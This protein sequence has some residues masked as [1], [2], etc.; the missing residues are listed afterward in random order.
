[1]IKK[2]IG[3]ALLLIF[4]VLFTGCLPYKQANGLKIYIQQKEPG[5]SGKSILILNFKE[6]DYAITKGKLAARIFHETVLKSKIFYLVKLLN[7]SDWNEF[8]KTEEEMLKTAIRIG[9]KYKTDF[10]LAGQITDYV[11]G[12]LN[13]TKVGIRVR[14]IEIKTGITYF[15]CAYVKS[16][17]KMDVSPPFKTKITDLSDLPDALLYKMADDIVKKLMLKKRQS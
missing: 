8:G 14:I 2:K 10:I 9:K 7:N 15:M 11:F 13:K 16:D 1:M 17:I 5:F 6:P 12:G 4:L 3:F